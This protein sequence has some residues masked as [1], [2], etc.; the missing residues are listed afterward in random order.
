MLLLTLERKEKSSGSWN[1]GKQVP[2]SSAKFPSISTGWEGWSTGG[3]GDLGQAAQW[4][5]SS[6]ILSSQ[7]HQHFQT[8]P[9]ESWQH[10]SM[11]APTPS[12]WT[13]MCSLERPE[14]AVGWWDFLVS[15]HGSFLVCLLAWAFLPGDRVPASH[16]DLLPAHSIHHLSYHAVELSRGSL[17][18][19]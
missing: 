13:E 12:N 9:F 19:H 7:R 2:Y 11:S 16:W 6:V 17:P 8:S 5:C 15:Y 4:M 18:R 14:N 1:R 3:P 10:G